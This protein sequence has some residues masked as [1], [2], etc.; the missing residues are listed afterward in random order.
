MK[1]NPL[2]LVG[3]TLLMAAL[4]LPTFALGQARTPSHVYQQAEILKQEIIL[5]RKSKGLAQTFRD[6]GVQYN[7]LPLHVYAKGLEV[8]EKISNLRTTHGLAGSAVG[9]IPLRKITPGDVFG[10]VK[11]LEFELAPVKQAMGVGARI[12]PVPFVG[13]K[14]PSD[15]Y[16]NLWSI[17]FALDGLIPALTPGHV[18][19]NGEYVLEEL[20]MI[21]S[22]LGKTLP[23][24]QGMVG[25]NRKI[26]PKDV[27]VESFK[28]LYRIAQLERKVGVP[29]FSP[30]SFPIG[31]I[32]PSDPFDATSMLLAELVRVK[33]RLNITK[34]YQMA[35]L[36]QGKTPG[37]VLM[38]ASR[39]GTFL[40]FLALN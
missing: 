34:D 1:I 40:E 7:K 10:L 39:A 26:T 31:N 37:D 16:Q 36:P 35:P 17:S 38:A 20:K 19:R 13:G 21:A 2:W 33:L 8:L 24:E 15:V 29:P 9:R 6:P 32:T 18:Y 27:L 11:K 12:A 14:L 30:P 3:L 22:A 23:E 5:L 28:N 25:A 4:F